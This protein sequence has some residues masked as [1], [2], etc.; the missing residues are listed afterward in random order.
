MLKKMR[1][2][3]YNKYDLKKYQAL[4]QKWKNWLELLQND[5]VDLFAR[6]EIFWDLQEIA[7]K[8]KKILTPGA[9][10]DWMCNN[11]MVSTPIGLRRLTDQDKRSVSL[12]RLLYE[13]LENPGVIN[14]ET[15][16]ALYRSD[17]QSLGDTAFDLVI[18]KGRKNLSKTQVKSDLCAI[19][20]A[21]ERIRRLVNKK[22]AHTHLNPHAIKKLP[23][24]N[25]LDQA[26]N[27]IDKVFC[28]YYL[29][30]TACEMR[31]VRAERQYDWQKVLYYPWVEKKK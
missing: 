3:S 1:P 7:K 19:E 9:F 16:K 13:I 12:W 18:G 5:L 4:R 22:I 20:K 31:S 10:F 15:Y 28:K 29:L 27:T 2:K 26:L 14:R 11:Y 6:Q 24:L 25:D 30:L 21:E 23:T 8:N 17:M